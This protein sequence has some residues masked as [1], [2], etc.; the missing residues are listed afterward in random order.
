MDIRWFDTLP[1]T[2]EYCKLLN[3]SEVEEFTVVAAREQTAG[4][5]QRGNHWHSQPG[6]NLT[7]SLVLKPT[8]LPPDRQFQLTK[9]LSLGVADF[10]KDVELK[11]PIAIKWPNDIYVGDRKI[12]GTL[13]ETRLHGTNFAAA[14]CGMGLNVNQTA[15]GAEAGRPTSLKRLTGRDFDL[16][17][18]LSRLLDAIQGRYEALRSGLTAAIDADY[19]GSFYRLGIAA[20][21]RADG[22][23]FTAT[24]TG[25]DPNGRLLL[26]TAD[27]QRLSF[28]M[29]E[30]EFI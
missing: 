21:Y 14:V 13:I 22:Q 17:E 20:A 29:K 25:V 8:F 2:N 27:G 3:L 18:T 23:D 28:A 15:F 4:R 26:T 16:D 9:A 24:A 7:F 19:L 1:S 10:L 11:E 6:L 30:V 5:G 12:C